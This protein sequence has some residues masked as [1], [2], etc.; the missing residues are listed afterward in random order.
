[1]SKIDMFK[2]FVRKNPKLINKVKN[3]EMTWQKYYELYELYGEDDDIWN[4]YIIDN[5]KEEKE[6]FKFNE[7]I[8]MVKNVDVDKVQSG[9]TSLQKALGLFGDLFVSKNNN[10]SDNYNPRPVYRR[11]D[12]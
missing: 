3:N 10:S 12:D 6:S 11:F 1:M 7:I 4:S 8:N 5:K 9:I 2:E